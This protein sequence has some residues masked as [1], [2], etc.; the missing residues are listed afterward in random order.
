MPRTARADYE[1]FFYPLDAIRNWNRLYGPKGFYQ[2]QC[3]VPPEVGEEAIG[4]IL[5]QIAAHGSGSFLAV[6]KQFGSVPS[7]GILSFP[8]PGPTLALDFPNR[9]ER[10]LRLLARLEAV[11]MEAGGALYP[12]KD[13]CMTPDTFRRSYPRW[14]EL[15]ARRDPAIQSDFWGRVTGR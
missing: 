7:P 9:G 4:E 1:P 14:E 8:R 13:A 3:V 5:D 11:A 15:E 6:L 2:F 12:A 10:T